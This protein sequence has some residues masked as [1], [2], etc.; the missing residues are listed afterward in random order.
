[1]MRPTVYLLIAI[2]TVQPALA[3]D[4][5]KVDPLDPG[6]HT[7]TIMTGEQKRTY[8]VHVPSTVRRWTAR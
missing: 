1:M 4:T 3:Q 2:A 5:P 7:R 8:L 6:D